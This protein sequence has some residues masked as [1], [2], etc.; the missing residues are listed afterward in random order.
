VLIST[1]QTR[2]G[3]LLDLTAEFMT[4]GHSENA[5]QGMSNI[6]GQ[7]ATNR[8]TELRCAE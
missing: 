4:H 5:A 8:K 3:R 2:R 7:T 1:L 6:H